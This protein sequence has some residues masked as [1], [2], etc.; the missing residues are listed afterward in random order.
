MQWSELKKSLKKDF[1]WDSAVQRAIGEK[2][3]SLESVRFSVL[4][5]HRTR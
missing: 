4:L 2:D 1:D 5:K 3:L